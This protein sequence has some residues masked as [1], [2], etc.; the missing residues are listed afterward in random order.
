MPQLSTG[1]PASEHV[2]SIPKDIVFTI[3][4]CGLFNLYVQ[5]RQ[6]KA[7]NAMLNQEKYSFLPWFLLTLI[8]CGL[9]HIYH[10]YRKSTDIALVMKDHDPSEALVCIIL[11]L[12]GL[13]IITDAIQQTHIN[14]H[15]GSTRL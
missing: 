1:I 12:F 2:R 5:S 14:R 4:T 9:Y 13:W 3:L 6:M 7:V 8:T 10:E 15:Y 11:T